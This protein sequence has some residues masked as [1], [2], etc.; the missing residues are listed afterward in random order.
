MRRGKEYLS[1]L[2][3]IRDASLQP[4]NPFPFVLIPSQELHNV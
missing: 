1:E 2:L 3:H 4:G